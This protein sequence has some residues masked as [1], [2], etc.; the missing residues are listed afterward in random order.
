MKIKHEKETWITAVSFFLVFF[1]AKRIKIYFFF[2]SSQFIS[3]HLRGK[4]FLLNRLKDSEHFTRKAFCCCVFFCCTCDFLR[5]NTIQFL[6]VSKVLLFFT[7]QKTAI[8]CSFFTENIAFDFWNF[9]FFNSF[10]ERQDLLK[11]SNIESR[12]WKHQKSWVVVQLFFIHKT[13]Y[14]FYIRNSMLPF[15]MLP[16]THQNLY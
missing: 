10:I 9:S 4:P 7:L 5:R 16:V 12:E 13:T 14:Y 3:I 8:C 6:R 15:S 2:Y 1:L 11:D